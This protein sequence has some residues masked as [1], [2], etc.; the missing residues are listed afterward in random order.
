MKLEAFEGA[1]DVRK[2]VEDLAAGQVWQFAGQV[3]F[4]RDDDGLRY[5]ETG[6]L[7][8]EG[9]PAMTATR[10]YLWRQT[11]AGIAVFFDD[12]RPFHTVT[13]PDKAGSAADVHFCD[14]DTYKVLYE[15]SD[16]PVWQ[17]TWVVRGPRKDYVMR[18]Y[19]RRAQA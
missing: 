8:R 5:V 17:S 2:T 18:S 16:W 3:R 4:D 9:L 13:A 1:W 10:E 14:P 6:Q 11:G 12:G 15:F 19:Y 7:T